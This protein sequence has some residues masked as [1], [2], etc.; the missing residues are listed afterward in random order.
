MTGYGDARSQI[1][2]LACQIE[3]RSVNN[4]HFKLMLRAPEPYN[5]LEAEFEKVI[6]R[7][8][9]RG[10]ILV[11]MRLERQS[12]VEDFRLNSVAL[13]SYLRQIHLVWTQLDSTNRPPL[14]SL[15]S[16]V[17][18]LPGV[19]VEPSATSK[20]VDDEWPVIEAALVEALSRLQKMREDEGQ[21][22][23][24]ELSGY[25]N[26]IA[27]H[28]RGIRERQPVVV[29]MFQDRMR[30][31]VQALVNGA[32]VAV[33]ET[34]LLREV[35]VFADRSDVSEEIVR[36]D[37]HLE[38]FAEIIGGRDESAGRKL[39]FVAQEMGREANTIGSKAA[40]V[41]I[42]RLVVDIKA[43]LEKIRELLQNVE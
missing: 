32:G 37:S 17:L 34:D 11:Q 2:A 29:P 31:R 15:C 9:R 5:L 24:S 28:L 26:D 10:T 25:R 18:A 33:I 7:F 12:R 41:T 21:R 40:D 13:Q 36:L 27:A 19:C 4:R 30:E 3:V 6:R 35:A 20:A 43:A 1:E 8:V 23:A 39:E 22:M 38:Q 16:Q 42:S 14:E